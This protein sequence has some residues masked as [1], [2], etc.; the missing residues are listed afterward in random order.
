MIMTKKTILEILQ[1]ENIPDDAK[2]YI[3]G[4]DKDLFCT[5]S[6]I[7]SKVRLETTNGNTYDTV[8]LYGES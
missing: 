2:I 1:N 3:E 8:T 4:F 7:V 5:I 6:G